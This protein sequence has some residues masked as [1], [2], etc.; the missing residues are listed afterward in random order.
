MAEGEAS[1]TRLTNSSIH[2][3]YSDDFSS[4]T[5][6]LN[7]PVDESDLDRAITYLEELTKPADRKS[8][9][10]LLSELYAITSH[11]AHDQIGLDLI[12][13][14]YGERLEKYS[15]QAVA[16]VVKNWSGKWFPSWFEL[17]EKIRDADENKRILDLLER[18]KMMQFQRSLG[19]KGLD[20]QEINRG[21]T[22]FRPTR[23]VLKDMDK[24]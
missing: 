20:N 19:D 9:A 13:K 4:F 11:P 8:I 14:S 2:K 5:L 3:R 6:S 15:A 18:Q 1:L 12:I 16:G 24:S 22:G 17:E 7:G 23:N 10:M 21:K